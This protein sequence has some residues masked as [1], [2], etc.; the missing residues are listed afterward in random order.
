MSLKLGL[1]LSQKMKQELRM[2]PQL[3]QAIRLLQLSNLELAE[4]IQRELLENP[5]LEEGAWD[6]E[7]DE[8]MT[9]IQDED[10]DHIQFEQFDQSNQQVE[11]QSQPE[12]AQPEPVKS[13]E[14]WEEYIRDTE[15][16]NRFDYDFRSGQ[17]E[18]EYPERQEKS[19]E[20][21]YEHLSWQLSISDL[22]EQE[23]EIAEFM[24][25]NLDEHGYLT[26][27]SIQEVAQEFDVLE[28]F[29]E[30]I[31]ESIQFFDPVG[32]ASLNLR[33]CLLAQAKFFQLGSLVEEVIQ[34]HLE[35]LEHRKYQL[36]AKKLKVSMAMV[37]QI[38][39]QIQSLEPYPSRQYSTEEAQYIT[40]DLYI[41]KNQDG[42]YIVKLSKANIPSLKIN[43]FYKKAILG[44]ADEETKTYVASKLNAAQW[45]IRSIEQRQNTMIR[46]M[47]SII[48]FQ[49]EFFDKGEEYLRPLVLK[50]VADDVDLHESTISR[51]T[52]N[53]FVSTPRGIYELKFFFKS[54]IQSSSGEDLSSEAVK[55]KIKKLINKEDPKKPYSD[56]QLMDLLENDGLKIARRTVAKYREAMNILPSSQRKKSF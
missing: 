6:E 9:A 55:N 14:D 21:I 7:Q 5:L 18:E 37:E 49:R 31:R 3:Q 27:V 24:I 22:S 30:E 10:G 44:G 20:S 13:A 11:E 25:A 4:E 2:T 50:T 26:Q 39:K 19:G 34:D 46:V 53:K 35:L 52:T 54:T 45:L 12:Q 36:L 42:E 40:P 15:D 47:Q 28:E 43:H 33:D 56:Q 29:V 48:K 1:V 38:A 51:V 23:K 17:E 32:S 41:E 8:Q 16:L